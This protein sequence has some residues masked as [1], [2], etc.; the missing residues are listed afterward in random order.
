MYSVPSTGNKTS[1]NESGIVLLPLKLKVATKILN[2]RLGPRRRSNSSTP[3]KDLPELT[4]RTRKFRPRASAVDSF[5]NP[6]GAAKLF[7][8]QM[9]K[10]DFR[11][12]GKEEEEEKA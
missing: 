4:P 12:D 2:F 1:S 5:G 6:G 11:N 8:T 7:K 3:N 10:M 9:E